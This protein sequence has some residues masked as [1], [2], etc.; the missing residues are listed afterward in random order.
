MIT[1]NRGVPLA[2]AVWAVHDDYDYMTDD[3]YIS[4]TGLMKPLRQIILGSRVKPG[5]KTPLDVQDLIASA[6]GTAMHDSVEKA[7]LN[8]KRNMPKLGFPASVIDKI[9]INPSPAEAA[10]PGI[11][12]IYM[13]VRTKKAVMEYTVGGKFDMIA[14]GLLQDNKS[15]TV[16]TWIYGGK[17][18]DYKL[19]GSLYR[20]LNPD[21][22]TEDYIQINFIFTD[23]SKTEARR[24]PNYPQSRLLEKKIPLMSIEETQKWVEWK[25]GQIRKYWNAPDEQI[26][27]C[28]D[29]ELWRTDPKFKY[30][31]DP[32]KTSGRA[33]RSYDTMAEAQ[34]FMN[35]RGKGG[36]IITIEGQVKRCG[37]CAAFP[38]CKQK[39]K[40]THD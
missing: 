36:V 12:P 21:K 19:Q 3:N 24:D 17:D 9:R 37:Y 28:T 35:E 1:N 14:D 29:E 38:T 13:E 16:Y 6:F 2:L 33:Y 30:Y 20:W 8:Y 15:T 22:V 18:E 4:V 7:W 40:Y 27:E 31:T 5:E 32:S 10:E 25:L 39:D 26:P 11:I 23:W 34:A